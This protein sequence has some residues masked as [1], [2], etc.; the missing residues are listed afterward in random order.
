MGLLFAPHT[1]DLWV[2]PENTNAGSEQLAPALVTT[3]IACDFQAV[4]SELY[5]DPELDASG[6][7][8]KLYLPETVASIDADHTFFWWVEKG[9]AWKPAAPAEPH[10]LE[11]DG[12]WT[13]IVVRADNETLTEHYE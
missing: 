2:S 10:D 1:V 3:G 5:L 9:S 13:V 12:H 11:D 7:M 8:R 4:K 6:E